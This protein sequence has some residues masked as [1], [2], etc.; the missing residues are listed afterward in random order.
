MVANVRLSQLYFPE[1]LTRIYTFNLSEQQI[2]QLIDLDP[3]R[4]EVVKCH[5]GSVMNKLDNA[6]RMIS[7]FLVVDDPT[8]EYAIVRDVDSRPSIRDLLAI[9]E[10]ISSGLAFHT[11]RDHRY[12]SVA[13]MGG[14]FGMKRGLFESSNTTMTNIVKKAF[15]DYPT[16]KIPGI[17]QDD[18]N[19]LAKYIWPVVKDHAMDH[20]M[21]GGLR[22]RRFG[23]KVC[24]RF[25]IGGRDDESHIGYPFNS[26]RNV[27][28]ATHFECTVS[29]RSEHYEE[30]ADVLESNQR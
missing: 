4:V 12:H 1:W 7:R 5:D 29:C 15:E 30:Y 23:S 14:M 19:F 17:T 22:C 26:E 13:V 28:R 21:D 18:Q 3:R 24:R 6:R 9:N 11:I 25:P 2:R 27:T 20:D 10:W 16:Q 8:V